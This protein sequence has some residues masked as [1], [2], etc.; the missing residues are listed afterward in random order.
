MDNVKPQDQEKSLK[1]TIREIAKDLKAMKP[2][3]VMNAKRKLQNERDA[4]FKAILRERHPAIYWEI[5]A[6]LPEK[7]KRRQP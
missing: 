5:V 4:V 3:A 6:A 7:F 1:D 2:R